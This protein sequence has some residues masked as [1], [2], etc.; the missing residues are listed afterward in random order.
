MIEITQ[1]IFKEEML[2]EGLMKT[3]VGYNI[4]D[5]LQ[6]LWDMPNRGDHT[7]YHGIFQTEA[8]IYKCYWKI[9]FVSN[10]SLNKKYVWGSI[11]WSQFKL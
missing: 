4:L 5:N 11:Y 8:K 9:I 3:H 6:T 7:N 1:H 10:V 2:P